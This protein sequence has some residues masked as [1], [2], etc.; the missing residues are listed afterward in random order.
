[1]RCARIGK[2]RI[3]VRLAHCN[4][5]MRN[6]ASGRVQVGVVSTRLAKELAVLRVPVPNEGQT[7]DVPSPIDEE[8]DPAERPEFHVIHHR[9]GT[10]I[11]VALLRSGRDVRVD[12]KLPG[13]AHRRNLNS[14]SRRQRK[15]TAIKMVVRLLLRQRDVF[16]HP[17][18]RDTR[19][20]LTPTH[21][22]K[23]TSGGGLSNPFPSRRH[24]K[25]TFQHLGPI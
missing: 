11:C 25:K 14:S 4:V 7:F 18:T 6:C 21:C 2:V 16:C 17:S 12:V 23:S 19:A 24:K 15:G 8:S 3:S 9:V 10:N 13:P 20:E 5:L 22:S 1:M